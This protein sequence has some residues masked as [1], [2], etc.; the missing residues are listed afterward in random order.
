VEE[1]IDHHLDEEQEDDERHAREQ[2]S[3]LAGH[4]DRGTRDSLDLLSLSSSGEMW[5]AL[6]LVVRS[7]AAQGRAL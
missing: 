5:R 1:S 4:G 3:L 7:L 2:P 6:P